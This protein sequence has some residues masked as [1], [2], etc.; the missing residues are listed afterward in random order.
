VTDRP[1][2]I[3]LM[4]SSLDGRLHPSRWTCSPD[5]SI[6][7]WSASYEAYHDALKA[8]AWLVGRAT[9]AEMA[10]GAPHPPARVGTPPRPIHVAEGNGPFAIALDR[11]GKLHFAS[12]DVGGD[13]AVV[14][15]GR[16]V[17]DAHL[18]ELIADGISYVVAEDEEM[19][20]APLIARLKRELGIETML[21]EGGGVVNGSFLA[22][23]LIDEFVMFLAPALDGSPATAIVEAG[24]AGL[25]GK[26]ALSLLACDRLDHGLLRLRYAVHVD[27]S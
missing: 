9:M 6:K 10:K 26:V 11:S 8:D 3:C 24:D 14:L 25:Q 4:T 16:G 15:L 20:L 18:A 1:K 7:D 23:G 22:A 27:Q 13:P 19:A 2:V 12:P 17:P 5:G 21:L